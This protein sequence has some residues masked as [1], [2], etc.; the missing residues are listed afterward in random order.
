M[1]IADPVL[2]LLVVGPMAWRVD[3]A[4][5]L[6]L[7]VLT[8]VVHVFGLLVIDGS[9]ARIDTDFAARRG[10]VGMFVVI[11]GLTSLSAALLHGIEGAIWAIAYR[12]VGAL[13]DNADATLY[14]LGAMTT[15]GHANLDLEK[16]WQVMGTLEALDGMLLFGLTTAFLFAIIQRVRGLRDRSQR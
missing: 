16:R 14:S 9:I 6:P 15:Y 2:S 3:W 1:K 11:I 7:I 12:L 4:L 5:G 13:P 10:Y 8:V